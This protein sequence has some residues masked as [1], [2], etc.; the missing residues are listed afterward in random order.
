MNLISKKYKAKVK[1]YSD[2][3]K[4][5][6]KE[7]EKRL[8]NF[9][10]QPVQSAWDGSYYVVE[11]YLKRV[12]K[13]PDSVKIASCTKVMRN[14]DGWLVGCTWRARNGFGGMNA[15]TNWFTIRNDSVVR[16]DK[17]SAYSF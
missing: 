1:F 6:E 3:I 13:D 8:A 15:E 12:A 4:T 17:A 10:K 9:G 11:N 7:K 2:K 16:M 14:K 5:E